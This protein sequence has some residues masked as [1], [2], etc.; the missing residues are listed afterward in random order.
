MNN[1][2]IF[3]FSFFLMCTAAVHAQQPAVKDTAALF[4]HIQMLKP[5]E[6]TLDSIFDSNEFNLRQMDAVAQKYGSSSKQADSLWK[7]ICKTDGPRLAR[8]KQILAQYGWLGIDEVGEKAN[9]AIFMVIQHADTT[10][11]GTYLP[12]MEAAVKNGKAKPDDLALLEDR[13]LCQRGKRQ[14]YGSQVRQN[15]TGRYE[16]FPIADEANVDKR[17]ASVGLEPLEQY[18]RNFDID[19]HLP[20]Q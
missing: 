6:A 5:V 20:K 11:Q 19:Y 17:R 9:A 18:A 3:I 10:T 15:K 12:I 2:H 1:Q 14:L 16:F 4:Q 13:V 8:V 7:K